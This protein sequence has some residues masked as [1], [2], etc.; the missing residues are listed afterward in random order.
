MVRSVWLRRLLLVL[1]LFLLLGPDGAGR[2][3]LGV[4]VLFRRLRVLFLLLL[5]MLRWILGRFGRRVF[6]L[7]L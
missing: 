2:L 6:R 4:L 3:G 5:C 7:T 1:D